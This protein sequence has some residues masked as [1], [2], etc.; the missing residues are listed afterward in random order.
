MDGLKAIEALAGLAQPTRL[1]VF[2]R[3]LRPIPMQS[4]PAKSRAD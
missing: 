2:R 4:Q 3:L 1:K